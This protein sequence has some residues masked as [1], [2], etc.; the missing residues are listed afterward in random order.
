MPPIAPSHVHLG[1]EREERE[2]KG[3][4]NRDFNT[5]LIHFSSSFQTRG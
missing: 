4:E 5:L 2:E 1:E 3:R